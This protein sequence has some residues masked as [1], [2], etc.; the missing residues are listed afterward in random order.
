MTKY[1]WY[2]L[3]VRGGREEKTKLAIEEEMKKIGLGECLGR[4]HVPF[5]RVYPSK[6]N[7]RE[8][9]KKYFAYIV[10]EMSLEDPKVKEVLMEVDNVLGFVFSTGWSRIKEP[11]PLSKAD[12]DNML[13]EKSDS[14]GDETGRPEGG[15]VEGEEVE[16]ID[17]AFQG[18]MAIIQ[19]IDFNRKR[20]E[21]SIRIFKKDTKVELSYNQVKRK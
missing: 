12:V 19:K 18:N 10:V 16:I 6:G 5:Q 7:K 14:S 17:G 15:L 11:I 20:I 8:A 2:A 3:K 21:V 13:G 1:S 4:I 9:R